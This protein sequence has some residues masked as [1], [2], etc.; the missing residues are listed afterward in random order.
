MKLLLIIRIEFQR[1]YRRTKITKMYS[2]GFINSLIIRKSHKISSHQ[3]KKFA[4]PSY[5]P[6]RKLNNEKRTSIWFTISD[7]VCY[8]MLYMQ[9]KHSCY[10]RYTRS[11]Q[12]E[13][14]C[15]INLFREDPPD[16]HVYTKATF[17]GA[18]SI[19]SL[20]KISKISLK[21]LVISGHWLIGQYSQHS[22]SCPCKLEIYTLFNYTHR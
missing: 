11:T 19:S 18:S 3:S 22:R 17:D 4:Y 5:I 15:D 7:F 21:S 9:L 2:L 20:N 12:Q 1:F 16:W 6:Q 13:N 14:L 8:N 10:N